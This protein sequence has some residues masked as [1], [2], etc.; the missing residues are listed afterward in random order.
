MAADCQVHNSVTCVL[1]ANRS[2]H[3]LKYE[4]IFTFICNES[5]STLQHKDQQYSFSA[6]LLHNQSHTLVSQ[7]FTFPAD[8]KSRVKSIAFR[9]QLERIHECLKT[10][11][12]Q[13]SAFVHGVAK[14]CHD[15]NC[16]FS[17]IARHYLQNCQRL[18]TRFL[19]IQRS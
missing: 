18:V 19:A 3:M 15:K 7:Q 8:I 14:M 5:H 10:F 13:I 6:R 12:K 17:E 9:T 2:A 4:T 11:N 1:S 16:T